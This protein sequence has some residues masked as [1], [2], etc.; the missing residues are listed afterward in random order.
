MASRMRTRPSNCDATLEGSPTKIVR[1][2]QT[3]YECTIYAKLQYAVK[4]RVGISSTRVK[5]HTFQ[6][7]YSLLSFTINLLLSN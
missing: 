6:L 5:H 1:A 7:T 4:A 2:R 3:D